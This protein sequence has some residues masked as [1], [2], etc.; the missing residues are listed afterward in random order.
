MGRALKILSVVFLAVVGCAPVQAGG[1][2]WL[3]TE[4]FEESGGWV[5][6][7]QFV[8]QMGS[9]YLL[10]VGLGRPVKDATTT[11]TAPG[12]GKYRLW[13]RTK[14]WAPKHHPGQFQ[15]LVDGKAVDHVFG[16]SGK[17]GWRWEDGGIVPL[18]GKTTVALR[19][20][21]GYY[22]RCD[23]IVLAAD[24]DWTPP[25]EMK[26]LAA[27]R[28]KHGGV[29]ASIRDMPVHDVVVVG[30]GL[31][32]CTA[33]V[34]AA[35]NGASVALIQNRPVLG[36]NASPEILVPPVGVWPH[37]IKR[38]PLAVTET[39]LI[40]EYRTAGRQL[41]VEGKLYAK[42]LERLVR[43]E[44]N[45]DLHLNT[46]GTGVE[47]V[48]GSTGRIAAAL[49][50]DVRTGQRMRFV[51]KLFIDCTGDAV[52]GAAAGAEYRTGKEPKSM[53]DEPWAP[54]KPS[55][56]TMGN[57]LKYY[58]GP[59][60]KPHPYEAPPWI[61]TF[62][63]CESFTPGR[64]PQFITSDEI[65]GQWKFELG[66]LRDT[67]ADAEEIRDDLLR[68]IYGLWDHTKNHC[69][70][71]SKPAADHKLLWVGHVTGK[72]E[73]RRLMGDYVLTQN[74]IGKQVLFP[75]R[76]ALGGWSVDDHYSAGFFHKGPTAMH[77]DQKAHHYKGLLFSIPFRC[78][79]SKNIENLM[80]AG[81]DVS[82]SHLGMSNIRVM[83][84]GAV[85]GHAAGT[86]A[87]MC[88]ARNTTPRELYRGHISDLQQQLLKEG[89]YIV[90]LV[91]NDRRDLARQAKVSAPSEGDYEGQPT[92]AAN[93]IDGMARF[94]DGKAHAWAP[95]PDAAGP[96][97][98]QLTWETPVAFNVVH[99]SF[100]TLA[101]SPRQFTVE[102]HVDGEWKPIAEVSDN[103][104]RRHVLGVDRIS[105]SKLRVVLTEA[106]GVCE[107][108]VYDE[109]QRLVDIARRAHRNM[110]LPD[111]G[112]W[113]PWPEVRRGGKPAPAPKQ[114]LELR[115]IV[116]D[117]S[118]ATKVGD[119]TASTWGQPYVGD[120][121]LH[122]GNTGKGDKSIRFDLG[123][124]TPG[125]YEVR[126]AYV[127]HTNRASNTPVTVHFT[128]DTKRL[129]ID[130][131]AKPPLAGLLLP[132]GTFKL[133]AKSALVVSNTDTDGYVIVD[134]VQLVPVR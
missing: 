11:F 86:G 62:A 113:L 33:A 115:G 88:V 42:R 40:E 121:Y 36:G 24:L 117:S 98:V 134:A 125:L 52:I 29:S 102:A 37:K 4:R 76:V 61:Y 71:N 92:P 14:D 12:P 75:D 17:A 103:R 120:G 26:A 64:H 59:T 13:A 57:G 90:G 21:T 27:T 85:M 2:L 19:D 18:Q 31:A 105:A 45:L 30:G 131:R 127:P 97:W 56:H 22:G 109:P 34:A 78:L 28:L 94:E 108:R 80:M 50:V 54:E 100:Q 25:A 8:D 93:V 95:S 72:R 10:A 130:Q 114:K 43:L 23:A 1:V 99:V 16:R 91:G 6:D 107:V 124:V 39:G 106:R 77:F 3:E 89:A 9:P 58:H 111:Q 55:K 122:D 7:P 60:D 82:A 81:R 118:A 53:Y 132:L 87:G 69:P 38:H 46:H 65:Q 110:R 66:G 51:G 48:R 35:R 83:L 79:Y 68:L 32:G 129:R 104:H 47:M 70:R 5:R 84:T 133:D 67:I 73:N 116:L 128:G 49:A 126:L 41:V 15:I 20:L 101:L 74:D 119:W 63:T 112:P 96:H 44:A 123:G